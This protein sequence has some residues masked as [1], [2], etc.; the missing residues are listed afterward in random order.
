MSGW[1]GQTLPSELR[2]LARSGRMRDKTGSLAGGYQ[3]ANIAILPAAHAEDFR[4]YVAANSAACPLLAIGEPGDPSLPTLGTDVDIRF[5]LPRYRVIRHGEIADDPYAVD[6]IWQDDLVTFALGCS[7]G[8]ESLVMAAGAELRCHAPGQTCSAFITDISTAEAGSFGGPLVV[9][10]RAVKREQAELVAAITA[11]HPE[12]HGGPIHIGDPAEIG[13]DIT[14]PI[15]GIGLTDVRPD[16][17]AMFWPCGVTSQYA[18]AQ[19]RLP[20]TITHFPGHMLVT[21]IGTGNSPIKAE[22]TP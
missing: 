18:L 6:D 7:L 16:E 8:F 14:R 4:A 20:L 22:G 3:Q 19:A 21:D 1:G 2:R 11:A 9:T 13:V 17:V 15:E 5:D 12:T 10:M